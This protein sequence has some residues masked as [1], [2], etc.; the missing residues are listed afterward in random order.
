M[1]SLKNNVMVLSDIERCTT[2]NMKFLQAFKIL[3]AGH[4]LT[5]NGYKT[6]LATTKKGGV[7]LFHVVDEED[8]YIIGADIPL[9]TLYRLIEDIPEDEI[10]IGLANIALNSLHI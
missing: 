6:G 1:G 8:E 7:Q 2:I 5:I 4:L 3:M 9:D 10:T